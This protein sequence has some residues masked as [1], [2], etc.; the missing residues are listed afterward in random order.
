MIK[1]TKK[2]ENKENK[3]NKDDY[4]NEEDWIESDVKIFL[5]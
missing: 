4:K 2:Y 3:L 5:F 1:L